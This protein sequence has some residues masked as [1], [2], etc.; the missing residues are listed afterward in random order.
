MKSF[1]AIIAL[2]FFVA[3]AAAESSKEIASGKVLGFI[4]NVESR[5]A[6]RQSPSCATQQCLDFARTI[7]TCVQAGPATDTLLGVGLLLRN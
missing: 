1:I 5:L 7:S 2:S 4:R 6:A 3:L